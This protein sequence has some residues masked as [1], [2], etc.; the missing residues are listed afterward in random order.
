MCTVTYI[1]VKEGVL[2]TSNRDENISRPAA[3]T[4]VECREENKAALFFPKDPLHGGSWFTVAENGAVGVLLNGAF[5]KHMPVYPYKKSRGLVL[6]ELMQE[7]NM[8]AAFERYGLQ[9]VEPFTIV[10]YAGDQLLELRWDGE[11]RYTTPLHI[12]QPHI[13][14]SVTLYDSRVRDWREKQFGHF[15][16]D[17]NDIDE[18][19]VLGFHLQSFDDAENGF[20]MQRSNGIQT[21][22]VTQAVIRSS[23]IQLTHRLLG[24]EK[25]ILQTIPHRSLSCQD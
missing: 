9:Q 15:I 7:K 4:I 3:D 8:A 13:W 16:Y 10:H 6:L 18:Q 11:S 2:I 20:V 25:T 1:P 14:S 5:E 17:H 22:S 21:R 23:G 12:Q 24:A 19:A